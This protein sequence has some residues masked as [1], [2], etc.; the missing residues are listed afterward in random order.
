MLMMRST[1]NQGYYNCHTGAPASVGSLVHRMNGSDGLL[2]QH[3]EAH[4]QHTVEWAWM[5]DQSSGIVFEEV[6]ALYCHS[7]MTY[8]VAR[9]GCTPV[10][11]KCHKVVCCKGISFFRSPAD[12]HPPVP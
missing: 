10:H 6:V 8:W 2:Y 3:Q 11:V 7:S 1:C 5:T 12:S 9:A 4:R